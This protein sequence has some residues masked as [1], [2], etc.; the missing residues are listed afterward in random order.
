MVSSSCSTTTTVL[1]SSRIEHRVSMSRALS[2]WCR[3]TEGSSRTYRRPCI[4]AP[5]CVA[6][7]RRWAS[8]PESEVV[9]RSRVRYPRPSE[10]RTSRRLT[11]SPTSRSPIGRSRSSKAMA[12]QRLASRREREPDEIGEGAATDAH[13][14]A[15][16]PQPRAA[17]GLAG[18]LG[19]VGPQVVEGLAAVVALLVRR[20]GVEVEEALDPTLEIGHDP[21]EIFVVAVE[22]DLFRPVGQVA[23][24]GLQGEVVARGHPLQGVA[25][26]AGAV[27]VPGPYGALEDAPAVVGDD[28]LRVHGPAAA[29][30]VTARAGPLGAV[31]RE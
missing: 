17:A 13:R 14:Q 20:G 24:R 3:P 18:L 12:R 5:I 19:E 16:G 6:R 15:L 7:R 29:E 23:D 2:R 9:A 22:Q 21:G 11:I 10:P 27:P 28:S 25:E 8:P 31:E 1:P 26:E 4:R 30:T